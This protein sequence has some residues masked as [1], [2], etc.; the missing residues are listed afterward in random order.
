[1]NRDSNSYTFLFTIIMV[2]LVA[3]TLATTASLLKDLQKENVRKEKMQSILF[4]I[5][6]ETDRENSEKLY[7]KYITNA[8]SLK[9]DGTID[10]EVDA[11]KIKLNKEIKKTPDQQRFPIYIAK[12]EENNYYIIP[13]IYFDGNTN[14]YLLD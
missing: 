7:N 4:S 5:G 3:T 13:L 1:M 11:F 10:E 12:V 9:S 2:L 8:L 6:I 14:E